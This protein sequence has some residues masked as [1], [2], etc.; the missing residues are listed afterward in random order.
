[1]KTFIQFIKESIIDPP[2]D[3][4]SEVFKNRDQLDKAKVLP[5]VKQA[6]AK[7]IADLQQQFPKFKIADYFMVG[8]SVTYQYNDQSDIDITVVYKNVSADDLATLGTWVAKSLNGHF[9][10]LDRK[11]VNYYATTSTRNH[12]DNVDAAYDVKKDVW[13]KKP[14]KSIESSYYKKLIVANSSS[15]QHATLIEQDLKVKLR[16]LYNRLL[17]GYLNNF[18]NM[19]QALSEIYLIYQGI[20]ELRK[21]AYAGTLM[22]DQPSL[23]WSDENVVYKFLDHDHY[24][25]L[26][27]YI[28]SVLELTQAQDGQVNQFKYQLQLLLNNIL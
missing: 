16:E 4:L 5:E 11:S 19:Q 12:L 9:M 28:K 7:G 20:H 17:A 1:M 18:T 15:K 22:K 24:L 10:F 23:N 26:F 2:S 21:Q 6:I 27:D 3:L 8:S 25:D 14:Q 13:I